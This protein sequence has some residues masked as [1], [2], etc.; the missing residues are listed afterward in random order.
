[1]NRLSAEERCKIEALKQ[2]GLNCS[3]I[4]RELGRH[5]TSIYRELS[6][7]SVDGTYSHAVATAS[8][9]ARKSI[10]GKLKITEDNW[11]YVRIMLHQ[12][13]SP[14][15]ISGWLRSTSFFDFYVCAEWI[16]EYIKKDCQN[17]GSLYTHLRRGGKPY[18][19]KRA[20]RG[21]I[22]DRVSIESRPKI[23]EDRL[24]IGHWEVD[25]AP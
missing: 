1:M 22:K 24:R 17:G 14:E 25:I 9:K 21:F 23:I 16:Y 4:A 11:D 18:K 20:Y 13:W 15:Q 19:N 3:Q 8:A 7:N 6:R 5:K 10:C 12:K 2:A